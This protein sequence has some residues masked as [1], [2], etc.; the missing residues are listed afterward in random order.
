MGGKG[1][2]EEMLIL[3]FLLFA[4]PIIPV[5][6]S[7][8]RD[9]DGGPP[10]GLKTDGS[11]PRS[12]YN[13]TI[14]CSSPRDIALTVGSQRVLSTNSPMGE[15]DDV[16]EV[17][18]LTKVGLDCLVRFLIISQA[19]AA[20]NSESENPVTAWANS[21]LHLESEDCQDTEG[22]RER[23]RYSF[24]VQSEAS[25]EMTPFASCTGAHIPLTLPF[26]LASLNDSCDCFD[27]EKDAYEGDFPFHV[28]IPDTRKDVAAAIFST[29]SIAASLSMFVEDIK[30]TDTATSKD[31][32]KDKGV[33]Q[34]V[35]GADA[36]AMSSTGELKEEPDTKILNLSPVADPAKEVCFTNSNSSSHSRQKVSTQTGGSSELAAS[37]VQSTA[38]KN[39]K[40]HNVRVISPSPPLLVPV[41]FEYADSS[42]DG[43]QLSP[44]DL[45]DCSVGSAGTLSGDS[46]GNHNPAQH[47]V[48]KKTSSMG[49]N[50][51]TP[52]SYSCGAGGSAQD[53]ILPTRSRS[54]TTSASQSLLSGSRNE[55]SSFTSSACGLNNLGNTCFMSS[56]LQCFVHSPL[57]KEYF[58]SGKYKEHLNPKNPLGTKGAILTKAFAQLIES[59]AHKSKAAAE[60]SA[61]ASLNIGNAPKKPLKP[62]TT[63]ASSSPRSS[64]SGTSPSPGCSA[65]SFAPHE[66]RRD[67]QACKS[68]FQGQ[69]QQDVQEFLAELMVS[70]YSRLQR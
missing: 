58:L 34:Q 38:R 17:L 35:E 6:E 66:F 63:P 42:H 27:S 22:A 4:E 20:D 45:D 47:A 18:A 25:A 30:L 26:F 49:L 48:G 2:R 16:G 29:A 37:N 14:G 51:W 23:P 46:T 5:S 50:S 36:L 39:R 33:D 8:S 12:C 11:Y 44:D 60:S 7:T 65:P 40:S 19:I 69:E 9:P 1:T 10:N 43:I 21:I 56:A 28:V 59:M 32:E 57:L 55:I 62:S 54:L 68:Q 24:S 31:T 13:D 15:K 64:S 61:T 70:R 53:G 3:L 41:P 67:L 52:S